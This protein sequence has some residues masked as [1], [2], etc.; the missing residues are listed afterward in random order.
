MTW[1]GWWEPFFLGAAGG[2]IAA[3]TLCVYEL[4]RVWS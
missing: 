3:M 2:F 1:H 4:K